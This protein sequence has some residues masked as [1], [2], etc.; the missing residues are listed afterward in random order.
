MK[1][2]SARDLDAAIANEGAASGAV[3]AAKAA[4]DAAQIELGYCE[5]HSPTRGIIGLTKAKMGEFVGRAPNPVILN[6]VSNLDP[7]NVRFAVSEKDYLYFARLKQ[8]EVAAGTES[9]PRSLTLI[10]AD[11]KEYAQQGTVASIDREIDAKTGSLTVEAQFPNPG[12]FV[13]PGQFAKIRTLAETMKG[14]LVVPKRAVRE[15]QG[16]SQLLVVGKDNTIE[17]RNVTL[18][19]LVGDT[20]I[21]ESGLTDGE[22]VA[23]EALDRL[24]TG[25]PVTPKLQQ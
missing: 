8:A 3:D 5:I 9:K 22:M 24:R 4:L 13:R 12:K 20:Q 6:T 2:L 11:G 18:G 17:I 23:L 15:L 25:N 19:R 14:A 7:I 16:Q 10:L 21:V 1:A